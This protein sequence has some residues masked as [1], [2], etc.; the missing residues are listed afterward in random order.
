MATYFGFKFADLTSNPAVKVVP[1]APAWRQAEPGL[2]FE[3]KCTTSSCAAFNKVIIYNC[4]F[5]GVSG[6]VV[7]DE[8]TDVRC[9]ICHLQVD[10]TTCAFNNCEWK[11]SG[12]T[13]QWFEELR[14]GEGPYRVGNAYHVFDDDIRAHWLT[15]KITTTPVKGDLV[16]SEF[17]CHLLEP[18]SMKSS[19][20]VLDFPTW[21]HQCF[22]QQEHAR[23][24]K[25]KSS[26]FSSSSFSSPVSPSSFPSSSSA[27]LP[28]SC[29]VKGVDTRHSSHIYAGD[30]PTLPILLKFPSKHGESI[31]VPQQIGI[32][33][34][35]FGVLLLK[36]NRGNIVSAIE[37]AKSH[38]AE[39]INLGILQ[40]W[41]NGEA[42]QKPI[43][44]NT[45]VKVLHDAEL[46]ALAS[47]IKKVLQ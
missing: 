21:G 44:W 38:D 15:L 39:Q 35:K 28:R 32:S 45:L 24:K 22:T 26:H 18:L 13:L 34:R 4:G 8:A 7:E 19:L 11:F 5:T 1:K 20:P 16:C 30:V 27:P 23:T 12:R 31:N 10:P 9:P 17:H 40:K 46:N 36:D 2:C 6:F 3:G 25:K 33:Y 41:I 43:T 29:K 42:G 37:K 14:I 47:D